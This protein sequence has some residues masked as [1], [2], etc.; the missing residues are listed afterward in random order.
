MISTVMTTTPT[1]L[2]IYMDGKLS[3][4]IEIP[5]DKLIETTYVGEQKNL[6]A[7]MILLDWYKLTLEKMYVVAAWIQKKYP[8]NTIDWRTTF[9][10]II[11]SRQTNEL[12]IKFD[13][14]RGRTNSDWAT[15]DRAVEI[16]IEVDK[17]KEPILLE[18][19]KALEKFNLIK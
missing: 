16:G 11:V 1:G 19:T 7:C 8:D 18:M 14:E 2:F 3:I 13:K 17:I 4:G 9:E 10:R 6:S 15:F 12:D 5:F